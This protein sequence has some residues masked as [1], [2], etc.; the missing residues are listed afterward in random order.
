MGSRGT[1]LHH[2]RSGEEVLEA[3]IDGTTHLMRLPCHPWEIIISFL[4]EEE[5]AKLLSDLNR[6][7]SRYDGSQFVFP[8]RLNKKRKTTE[9]DKGEVN[10]KKKRRRR[11]ARRRIISLPSTKTPLL[12]QTSLSPR[13]S[14]H[15]KESINPSFP[16]DWCSIHNVG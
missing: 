7:R 10:V 1:A 8:V 9:E 13:S 15:S 16:T 5:K 11:R 3:Y 2:T 14:Y 6:H 4:T 12:L